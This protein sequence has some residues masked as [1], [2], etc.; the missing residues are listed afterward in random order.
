M[1]F[2][3]Q[4]NKLKNNL[5]KIEFP[6]SK[7]FD[8][9]KIYNFLDD[10]TYNF[11]NTNLPKIDKKK[12]NESFLKYS[13]RS[14]QTEY[15][16]FLNLNNNLKKIDEFFKNKI[17]SKYFLN[18]L[19]F[20]IIKA[21]ITDYEHLIRMF[22]IQKFNNS[23]N[24]FFVSNL[25]TRVEFSYLAN[26]SVVNPHTDSIKKMIS[27]MLYFPDENS[28]ITLSEQKKFG[29]NFWSSKNKNFE[30]KHLNE[31]DEIHNFTK[32]NKLIYKTN[33]EKFHLYGFIRNSYSWHSV[34]QI[35]ATDNYY[36]KSININIFFN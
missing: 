16:N 8:I 21:R 22:K 18:K 11:I 20:R 28:S 25:E 30:N 13:I 1:H 33:F 32:Q 14:N 9:F 4:L 12:F 31:I 6:Y 29:T 5:F 36:R 35:I 34:D 17:F 10:E 24:S 2:D 15:N 19:F 23:H 3:K 26:K 27:L 7:Q